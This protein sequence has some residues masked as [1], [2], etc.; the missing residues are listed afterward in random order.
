MKI[1]PKK[2]HF[3]SLNPNVSVFFMKIFLPLEFKF[4]YSIPIYGQSAQAT[5][6]MAFQIRAYFKI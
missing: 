2:S 1:D 3:I 5:N 4:S 6:T